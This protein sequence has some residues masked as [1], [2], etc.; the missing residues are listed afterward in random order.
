MKSDGTI[1][2][3]RGVG[4]EIWAGSYPQGKRWV[5]RNFRAILP[6]PALFP[7]FHLEIEASPSGFFSRCC[8][9]PQAVCFG[10]GAEISAPYGSRIFTWGR[11]MTRSAFLSLPMPC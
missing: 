11:P 6:S 5:S 10:D 8:P 1:W 3:G 2:S 7:L 9:L 4:A